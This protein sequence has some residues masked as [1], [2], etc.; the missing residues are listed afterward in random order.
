MKRQTVIYVLLLVLIISNAFFLFHYL[1]K[2]N[3]RD[4]K[5]KFS[6]VKELNFNEEQQKS[7]TDLRAAHF[8]KMRLYSKRISELKEVM[9][10]NTNYEG[11]SVSFLDSITDL[12]AVEEKNKDLE[13]YRHFKAVRKICNDKQKAELSK[14]IKDA[15][16]R[17]ANKE[18]PKKEN[19]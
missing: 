16:K 14:I 10:A 11:V 12:I 1:G 17:R 8:N 15:I 5:S 4:R 18:K 13:M 7:Y 19:D 3:H 6:I 9:Y 2:P